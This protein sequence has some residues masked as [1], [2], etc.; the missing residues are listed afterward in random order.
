M[1]VAAISDRISEKSKPPEEMPPSK[2]KLMA[3]EASK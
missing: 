3:K 1:L 2:R